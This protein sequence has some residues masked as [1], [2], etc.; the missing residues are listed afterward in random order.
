MPFVKGMLKSIDLAPEC[1]V[2][3][4]LLLEPNH[5]GEYSTCS[6]KALKYG[7]LVKDSQEE[8]I[9]QRSGFCRQ[10]L[11]LFLSA[12]ILSICI[13]FLGIDA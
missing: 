5:L 8:N 3:G 2:P 10:A 6:K 12:K 13:F 9:H 7:L 11:E 4:G 1:T